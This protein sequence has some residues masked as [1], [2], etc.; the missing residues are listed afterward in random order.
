MGR[1]TFPIMMHHMMVF[2][3]IKTA[4]ALL[5]RQGGIFAGFDFAAY[6]TD[7]YYCYLPRGIV[8]LKVFYLAAG[9]F[10]PLI[11]KRL[12][13]KGSDFF[14]RFVYNVGVN[15]NH[16]EEA[17]R[18]LNF[19]REVLGLDAEE[20]PISYMV[21]D[22]KMELMNEGGRGRLGHIGFYTPDI[23]A[24]MAYLE[25]KGYAMDPSTAR[26]EADGKTLML[27]YLKEEMNGFAIH[28]TTRK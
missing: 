1:N 9:L 2:L 10:L 20:T 14:G 27:I 22:S 16:K 18:F 13:D 5:A 24:A 19:C 4:Y 23:Q 21:A 17:L 12:E 8:Q 28:L 15:A 3:G 7:F 11:F 25:E 6:K 26:Y